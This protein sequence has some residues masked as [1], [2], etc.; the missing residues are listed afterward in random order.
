MSAYFSS[1]PTHE[2][3][4]TSGPKPSLPRH[5]AVLRVLPPSFIV[6]VPT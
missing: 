1:S 6:I 5:S 2:I 3:K 4:V